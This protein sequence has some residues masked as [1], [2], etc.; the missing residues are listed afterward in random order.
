M[1]NHRAGRTLLGRGRPT[2]RERLMTL[3]MAGI[4]LVFLAFPVGR[5]LELPLAPRTIGFALMAAF[6]VVYLTMLS[7]LGI[8]VPPRYRPRQIACFVLLVGLTL[9]SIPV[10]GVGA[11]SYVPFLVAAAGFGLWTPVNRLVALAV[12]ALAVATALWRG[13]LASGLGPLG[14]G[15]L[16]LACSWL[17][18]SFI[19]RG[20]REEV[21][22]REV[23]V[24]EER[25]RIATDVHDLLGHSL[26]VVNLKLQLVDKLLDVDPEHA[27]AELRATRE[28][29][30]EALGGVR[31]TV[32][33]E[34]SRG[35]GDAI[36]E[37][38][39]ALRGD[40]IE[41]ELLGD[42]EQVSGPIALVLG[43]VVREASTNV[44]RHAHA[45]QVRIRVEPGRLLVDDDGDGRLG[46][47]EG[48]GIRGMRERVASAGGA[49]RV[50]EGEL[51]GTMV[52]VTW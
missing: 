47:R 46:S 18:V 30:T 39:L 21:L 43:W 5:L 17:V 11:Q 12:L 8:F 32:S 20:E 38:E 23:L 27:R 7:V 24:A 51:G 2:F 49:L 9:A 3:G 19:E 33:L 37:A 28:I 22:R 42:P 44:L 45:S 52:E 6:V 48:N 26:T 36:G 13:E 10:L 50:R 25:N 14:A 16:L 34:R 15:L 31:Q 41:V 35:L 40:G 4:W 29:V 1:T